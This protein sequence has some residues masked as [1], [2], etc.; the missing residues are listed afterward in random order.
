MFL[1]RRELAC[2]RDLANIC[3]DYYRQTPEGGRGILIYRVYGN[4]II[5]A[6]CSGETYHRYADFGNILGVGL[7]S[8]V[9]QIHIFRQIFDT[10]N[11]P[12]F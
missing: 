10:Q 1:L 5:V 8:Q 3:G 6:A 11:I 9:F 4:H 7:N 12:G 2:L